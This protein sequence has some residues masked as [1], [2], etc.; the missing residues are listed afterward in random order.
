[1]Q[2][3]EQILVVDGFLAVGKFGEAGVDFVELVAVE[4]V[5]ESFETV[6]QSVT[7]GVFA[8]DE[9]GVARANGFGSHD[10]VGEGIGHHAVLVD[11][12]LMGEGVGSDDGLIGR[13]DKGDT[14]GEHLAGGVEL[15][16]D[17]VVGVR[18]LVTANHEG[19]G[20]LFKNGVAGAFADCH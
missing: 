11:A 17:D 12:R 4:R 20:D 7:A 18:K 5:A 13:A 2:E 10:L 19:G 3:A 1:L 16:Q 14:L 8:E 6:G 15:A 9:L